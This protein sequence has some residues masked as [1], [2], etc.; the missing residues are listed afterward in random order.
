MKSTTR[1]TEMP[2]RSQDGR[3]KGRHAYLVLARLQSLH[4]RNHQKLIIGEDDD[5]VVEGDGEDE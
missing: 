4:Q 5:A 2:K 1:T 3:S